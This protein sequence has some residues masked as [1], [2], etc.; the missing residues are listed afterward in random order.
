MKFLKEDGTIEEGRAL[1][2]EQAE[3]L[4]LL[5]KYLHDLMCKN[6]YHASYEGLP[7]CRRAANELI[8]NGVI[9]NGISTA[10]KLASLIDKLHTKPKQEEEP[11]FVEKKE[12]E[13]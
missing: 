13:A 7:E 8:I 10:E 11:A 1:A 2:H 9:A 6:R 12:V 4:E 5:R 3:A